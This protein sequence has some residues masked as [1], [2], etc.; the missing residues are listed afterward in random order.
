VSAV[1]VH[2][3][4]STL[5]CHGWSKVSV[6]KYG[7]HL[8]HWMLP[9]E[10]AWL[11]QFLEDFLVDADDIIIVVHIS[12]Q[13]N[14]NEFESISTLSTND[15]LMIGLCN[16]SIV[17]WLL[18]WI[19]MLAQKSKPLPI[20]QKNILNCIKACQWLIRRHKVKH[21]ILNTNYYFFYT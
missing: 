13:F 5:C 14:L 6:A 15:E 16:V 7:Q 8:L 2:V 21:K 11:E 20:Y 3:H 18:D 4:C 19:Y 1:D 9:R 17:A 12:S 10:S